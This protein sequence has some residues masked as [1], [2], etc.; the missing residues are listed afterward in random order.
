M[1]RP[2]LRRSGTPT[3]C[4]PSRAR[5]WCRRAGGRARRRRRWGS[6][7]RGSG[8]RAALSR[9]G[10]VHDPPLADQRVVD[11]GGQQ[12]TAIRPHQKPGSGTWTRPRRVRRGRRSPRPARAARGPVCRRRIVA[13]STTW[14]GAV[15]D[16]H[17]AAAG[18]S[19]RGSVTGPGVGTGLGCAGGVSWCG[20]Y[21]L[22]ELAI[23]RERHGGAPFRRPSSA[24]MPATSSRALPDGFAGPRGF[25]LTRRSHRRS[26]RRASAQHRL[27]P[28]RSGRGAQAADRVLAAVGAQEQDTPAVGRDRDRARNAEG[29][30]LVLAS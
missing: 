19:M 11:P 16:V 24:T 25:R 18:G 6:R 26:G 1:W 8:S 4:G 14:S 20:T 28:F 5:S 21:Q 3:P 10:G 7:R 9:V 17:D 2:T 22:P 27:V 12:L 30:A 23:K 15:G 29:K 13:S